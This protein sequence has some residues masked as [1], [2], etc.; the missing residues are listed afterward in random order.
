MKIILSLIVA[1][2]FLGCSQSTEPQGEA[3]PSGPIIKVSVLASGKILIDGTEATLEQVEQRFI[4]LKSEKGS[5]WYYREAGQ[6]EP[7]PEA[8][9][10]IKL[11][12]DNRLPISLSSKPDFS[13]Y[14]GADGQPHPRE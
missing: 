3:K 9:Q 1:I 10:V 7:P 4:A 12:L 6:E 14:V 2:V 11:V 8:T 5:V 13:D